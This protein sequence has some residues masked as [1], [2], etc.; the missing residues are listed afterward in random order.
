[1]K[2]AY[3]THDLQPGQYQTRH[4]LGPAPVAE[5]VRTRCPRCGSIRTRTTSGPRT[6]GTVTDRYHHCQ[7]CQQ[8]F[9]SL[10]R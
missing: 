1:M 3:Q 5:F 9:R 2:T 10:L 7:D 8:N 6:R 4:R